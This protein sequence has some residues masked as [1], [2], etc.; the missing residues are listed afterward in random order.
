MADMQTTWMLMP[1]WYAL[2]LWLLL[3]LG[4]WM[5]A[6]VLIRAGYAPWWALLLLVPLFYIIGIWI[7]A[8][9]RWPRI[10]RVRVTPPSDYKGGWNVPPRDEN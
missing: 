1:W 9:A 8:F 2:V 7:F 4:L 5:T 10:D 3:A 6:R